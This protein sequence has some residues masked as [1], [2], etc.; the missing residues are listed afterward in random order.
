[1]RQV[2]FEPA[3]LASELPPTSETARPPGSALDVPTL[4]KPTSVPIAPE[5]ARV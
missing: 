2:G 1:M 3:I 4:K 5:A